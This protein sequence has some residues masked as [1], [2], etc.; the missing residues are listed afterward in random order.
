MCDVAA[1]LEHLL[2]E[3]PDR[4]VIIWNG[5]PIHRSQLIKD[6]LA[7]GAAQL[8][9]YVGRYGV[10]VDVPD[11]GLTAT[12]FAGTSL[13]QPLDDFRP[14]GPAARLAFFRD[15]AALVT[16]DHTHFGADFVRDSSGRIGWLRWGARIKPRLS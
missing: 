14:V 15:D 9:E 12:E 1:F 2:C 7:N 8:A 5:A 16:D 10:E 11:G 6:F 4:I 13:K 3:V